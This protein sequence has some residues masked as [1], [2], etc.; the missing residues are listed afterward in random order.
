MDPDDLVALHLRIDGIVKKIMKIVK[1]NK[2]L[3]KKKYL[4]FTKILT[5][6]IQIYYLTLF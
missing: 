6:L 4:D 3:K 1:I 5:K 2:I